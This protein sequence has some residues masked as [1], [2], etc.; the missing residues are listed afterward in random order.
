MKR[1]Q[2]L[3]VFLCV[4]LAMAIGLERLRIRTGSIVHNIGA[5]LLTAF[6]GL[7]SVLGLLL[8]E[9]PI[10]QP[11]DIDGVFINLILLGYALPQ[12]RSQH[13]NQD[14]KRN[15]HQARPVHVA[16]LRRIHTILG[17]IPPALPGDPVAHL[18][19]AHL[20]IR[21]AYFPGCD[22]IL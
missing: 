17:N 22:G 21:V 3:N 14:T 2:S 4:A 7:A 18:K 13:Y 16:A 6:A 1:R 19:Q 9:N 11:M 5:I 10:I 15:I 12:Q 8:Q 20:V